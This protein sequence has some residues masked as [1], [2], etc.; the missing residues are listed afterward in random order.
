MLCARSVRVSASYK[1]ANKENDHESD[2]HLVPS[3]DGSRGERGGEGESGHERRRNT[4]AR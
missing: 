4:K 2:P 3:C 1:E